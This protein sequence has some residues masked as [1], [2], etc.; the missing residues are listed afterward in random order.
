MVALFLA[1]VIFTIFVLGILPTAWYEP[2]TCLTSRQKPEPWE[3][4][5][6]IYKVVAIGHKHY[7]T[8]MW[9]R[10]NRKWWDEKVW[11]E[12]FTMAHMMLTPTTCPGE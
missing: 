8:V 7:G 11:S 4:P 5:S 1:C 9:D 10:E 2:G 12:S 6:S 3:K